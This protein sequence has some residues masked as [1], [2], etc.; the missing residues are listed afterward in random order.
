MNQV[1]TMEQALAVIEKAWQL[2]YITSDVLAAIHVIRKDIEKRKKE[3]VMAFN[4]NLTTTT[5]E[6]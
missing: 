4:T 3:E 5:C 1:Q 2:D 6:V